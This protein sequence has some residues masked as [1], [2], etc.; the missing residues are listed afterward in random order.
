VESGVD[1]KWSDES[2]Q[3]ALA[4]RVNTLSE[5]AHRYR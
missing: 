3:R 4:E 5:F 1:R 2:E